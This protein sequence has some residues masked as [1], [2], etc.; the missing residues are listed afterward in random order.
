M[1]YKVQISNPMM[2]KDASRKMK[3]GVIIV[4]VFILT[5]LS[6]TNSKLIIWDASSLR[7]LSDL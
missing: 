7:I 2:K 3:K 6:E 4:L 5:I 1:V